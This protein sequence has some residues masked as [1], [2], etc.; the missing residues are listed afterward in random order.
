MAIEY[1]MTA[2]C[3]QCG[4]IIEPPTDVKKGLIDSTRWRWLDK[5]KKSGVMVGPQPK[6]RQAKLY[7]AKCAG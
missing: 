5:W 3:D 7:C 2:I 1:T 6:L 4:K